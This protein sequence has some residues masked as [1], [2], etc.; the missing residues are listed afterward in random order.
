M[1]V[2][3]YN[4]NVINYPTYMQQKHNVTE[5]SEADYG[6]WFLYSDWFTTEVGKLKSWDNVTKIAWVVYKTGDNWDKRDCYTSQA[7][8]YSNLYRKDN[9]NESN[10]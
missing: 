10:G 2:F 1:K 7:T 3:P 6:K 4:D 8:S 9:M 5:L